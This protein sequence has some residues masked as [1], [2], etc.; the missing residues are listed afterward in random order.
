MGHISFTE[1]QVKEKWAIS[2]T[3]CELPETIRQNSLVLYKNKNKKIPWLKSLITNDQVQN[4]WFF[5]KMIK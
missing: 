3:A 5:L 1:G 4:A 2:F